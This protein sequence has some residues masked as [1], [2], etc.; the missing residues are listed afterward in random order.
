MTAPHQ[1][2]SVDTLQDGPSPLRIALVTETYPPEINGVAMTL[3]RLVSSLMQRGHRV[4]YE[5]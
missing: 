5:E 1:H 2:I 3:Q 4:R